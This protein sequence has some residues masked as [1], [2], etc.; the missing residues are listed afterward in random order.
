[1]RIPFLTRK[2]KIRIAAGPALAVG[3]L[4]SMTATMLVAS[5][6]M[7]G[8]IIG[9]SVRAA[10]AEAVARV[11]GDECL[12]ALTKLV[13]DETASFEERN[14][15]IWALGQLGDRRALPTL[16]G[17]QNGTS[18]ERERLDEALSQHEIDKAIRLLNSGVNLT[19][20]VW[21]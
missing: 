14:G 19:A 7:S 18:P 21:R 8:A 16:R 11:A 12:P 17:L 2:P 9:R 5:F 15:A 6:V 1:M 13:A 4:T 20:I 10:C 3:L